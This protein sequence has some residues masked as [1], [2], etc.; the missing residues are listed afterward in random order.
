MPLLFAK[1][2]Q[3]LDLVA[4]STLSSVCWSEFTTAMSCLEKDPLKLPKKLPRRDIYTESGHAWS[5]MNER[6]RVVSVGI[7]GE[8][9]CRLGEIAWKAVWRRETEGRRG[10]GGDRTSCGIMLCSKAP[11]VGCGIEV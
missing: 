1:G 8:V 6:G 11:A 10:R 9:C 4:G 7:K 5:S 2:T 3:V